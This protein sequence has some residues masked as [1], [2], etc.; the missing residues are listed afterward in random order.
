M[1]YLSQCSESA[2]RA[3][4]GKIRFQPEVPFATFDVYVIG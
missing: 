1:V 4:G 2:A 3:T